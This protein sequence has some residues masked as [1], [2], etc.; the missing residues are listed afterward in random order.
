V[1]GSPRRGGNAYLSQGCETCLR[2]NQ[3]CEFGS[4]FPS[5]TLYQSHAI[6]ELALRR[7]FIMKSGDQKASHWDRSISDL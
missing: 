6:T 2:M 4:L 5:S 7:I 1:G 3:Q